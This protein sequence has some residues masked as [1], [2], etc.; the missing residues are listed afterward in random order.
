MHLQHGDS[1]FG[2]IIVSGYPATYRM[3]TAHSCFSWND[4]TIGNVVKKLCA[5]TKV[6]L[7][8]NPT[9]KENKDYICQYEESDFDFIRRLAY[10]E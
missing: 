5:E 4:T 10:I 3:E 9:F 7:E 2:C 6:Q 8:L 1:D